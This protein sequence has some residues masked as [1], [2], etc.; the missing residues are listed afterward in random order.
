M[1]KLKILQWS[2]VI[3]LYERLCTFLVWLNLF[4][5]IHIATGLL[6]ENISDRI[7]IVDKW[8]ALFLSLDALWYQGKHFSAIDLIDS[9]LS[10]GEMTKGTFILV[11]AWMIFII[12]MNKKV[13]YFV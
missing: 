9:K 2:P 3:G 6:Q 4:P 13:V 5:V 11:V 10:E 8:L 12:R 7:N 1:T